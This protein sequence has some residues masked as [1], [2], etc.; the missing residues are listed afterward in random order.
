MRWLL[1]AAIA[2]TVACGDEGDA[3]IPLRH[4][5]EQHGYRPADL[6]LTSGELWLRD[7]GE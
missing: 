1:I 4:Y 5:A 2:L 6:T 7:A 3:E